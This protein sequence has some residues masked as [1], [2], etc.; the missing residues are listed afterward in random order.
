M[1]HELKPGAEPVAGYTLIER[2]GKGGFGEVWKA[3]G[4]GGFQVALKFVLLGENVGDVELRALEVIKGIR[5]P[6]LLGTFGSWQVDG[7][8]IIAM[9]LADKT[10]LDRF[11]EAVGQGFEG[12]PAPEI[13]EHFLDA[14]KASTTSTSLDTRPAGAARRASSTAT[15]SRRTC[16]WS[17]GA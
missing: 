5:H 11:R 15:S 1:N 6:H 9:E 12:I 17:V 3:N 13:F 16:S 8:L 7:Q 4:P 14:A 10:L 2:L